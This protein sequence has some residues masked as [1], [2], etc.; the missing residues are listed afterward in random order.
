VSLLLAMVV[1]GIYTYSVNNLVVSA[2][3]IE[4]A[5]MLLAALVFVSL[6]QETVILTGGIDIS[7][8]PLVGLLVVLASFFVNDGKSAGLIV[9]ALAL[10]LFA[11]VA[12]GALNGT[13]VRFM[14]FTPIAATLTVAIALQGL[15]LLLRGEPGGF[16]RTDVTDVIT[17][18]IGVVPVAFIFAV[19]LAVGMELALRYRRWGLNLRAAGSEE[20]AA[21]RLG[22]KVN[23]TV[24]GAYVV[25]GLFCFLGGIMLMAQLGIG[26][27][28]QGTTYTLASVTAVVLGGTS[29]FG[30]RGSYIGALLGAALVQQII[31]AT[32][33]LSLSQA[34]Q[35]WLTG[36]LTLAAA[37]TYTQVRRAGRVP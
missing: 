5:L 25:A 29:L 10:M 16:I 34:W 26:D 31:N 19:V 11:A 14:G 18:K 1:F 27:P 8:G 32:T 33:F 3:N 15:S 7:V 35:Y 24:V 23:R 17:T 9:F 13:L 12:V 28:A 36:L 4:S 21:R 22:V 6:A 37:A 20:V 2:F 30:G